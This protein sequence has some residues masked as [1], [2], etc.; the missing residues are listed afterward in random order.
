MAGCDSRC[1]RWTA[2]A[3]LTARSP[4]LVCT[5]QWKKSGAIVRGG[6]RSHVGATWQPKARPPLTRGAPSS[7]VSAPER[8]EGTLSLCPLRYNA[9]MMRKT[10]SLILI[11]IACS[12]AASR[13][14][15]A[16]NVAPFQ[17]DEVTLAQLQDGMASGRYSSRR[18]VEM[19]TERINAVDRQ[20]PASDQ[21]SS[22]IPRRC[23]SPIRSTRSA[24]RAAC[25]VRCTGFPFSS[26]TTSTPRIG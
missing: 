18:L 25:A 8:S 24:R 4:G 26:K 5:S 9:R 17:L 11:T 2:P 14:Q 15:Q 10:L 20:G 1:R 6:R 13:A 23:R 16:P 7:I 3:S 21:S 19:Y 22:S 12:T